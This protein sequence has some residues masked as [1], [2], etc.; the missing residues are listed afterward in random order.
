MDSPSGDTLCNGIRM[1]RGY[2]IQRHLS[3][4]YSKCDTQRLYC[5][6]YEIYGSQA[7]VISANLIDFLFFYVI[8][9][10]IFI[11]CYWRIL[12]AIRR[13]AKVMA[14]HSQAGPSNASQAQSHR[15]QTN[16]IKTMILVSAFY[17]IAWSPYGVYGLLAAA[18]LPSVSYFDSA[19]YA[20][21]FIAFLYTTTNPFI[22]AT[23]FD[24]VRE[25]LVKMIPWKKNPVQ[26][27][28]NTAHSGTL[29]ATKQTAMVRN[30]PVT[31]VIN[32]VN[33]K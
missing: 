4:L 14:S 9:F 32:V 27:T 30:T 25:V 19:F 16:V 8:I 24:P 26:P 13:Q 33:M 29:T 3:D 31:N 2:C 7:A 21:T 18:F 23:K 22:Y 6:S 20:T 1:V 5:S 17:A 28:G 11:F 12:L 10:F 15:I